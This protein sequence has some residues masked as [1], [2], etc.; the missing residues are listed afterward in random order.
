MHHPLTCHGRPARRGSP[1]LGLAAL[2]AAATACSDPPPPTFEVTLDCA[3][4]TELLFPDTAPGETAA[5]IVLAT[6][7]DEGESGAARPALEGT[8]AAMF[9]IVADGTTCSGH[10][11]VPGETC[12]TLVEYKPTA[13][14]AHAATLR[15]GKTELALG[16]AAVAA[17]PGLTASIRSAA[18]LHGFFTVASS[19]T[20]RL[21]NESSA[22]ITLSPSTFTGTGAVFTAT[23]TC[24]ATLTPGTA[25]ELTLTA[26]PQTT[27]CAAGTFHLPTSAR[28]IE[29][30]LSVGF[31]GGVSLSLSGQGSGRVVSSPP[32]LDCHRDA[33]SGEQT[34]RCEQAFRAPVTLTAIPDA[35][36][37]F[38][39]WSHSACAGGEEC[40]LAPAT[41]SPFG[42]SAATAS[43]AFASPGAKRLEVTFA[44]SGK[45]FVRGAF[46]CTASCSGWLEPET[47]PQLTAGS[48]SRFIG[49]SGACS[50]S[51]QAC[52]LGIV[53]NDLATTV[54][55][56]A[57]DREQA[58]ILPR[59]SGSI[60]LGGLL[61]DGDLV[62]A[63]EG[64]GQSSGP[65]IARLS[66]AGDVRWSAT[67]AAGYA[68]GLK[69]TP[70]GEIYALATNAGGSSGTLSKLDGTG[71]IAWQR[72]T[73]PPIGSVGNTSLAVGPGGAAILVNGPGGGVVRSYAAD[74]SLAWAAPAPPA[75]AIAIDPAGITAVAS[76]TGIVQRFSAAGAALA[77]DWM[78]PPTA[79]GSRV[80][81]AYD[82]QGFLDAQ[83]LFDPSGGSGTPKHT[84]S[85]LDL[86]GALIFEAPIPAPPTSASSAS[87]RTGGIAV[88]ASAT[89][90]S[91]VSHVYTGRFGFGY[92]AGAL[93]E[94]YDPQGARTWMLDKPAVPNGD[95]R[96]LREG[97]IVEDVACGA[98]RCAL[99]GS[100]TLR[101]IMVPWIQVFSV[102]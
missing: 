78:L 32:G 28:T 33:V 2:A 45:G 21:I 101:D 95:V 70:S 46:N 19:H 6:R 69:V 38:N 92:A 80:T 5:A 49:W 39:G 41:M 75:V 22:D 48:P 12:V 53:V 73:P 35:G 63:T 16:G 47:R 96:Q 55:F 84:L 23:P 10:A 102:P 59:L 62:V 65:T 34:G 7:T 67:L 57:D 99:F 37:H 11:L 17:P 30:P 86:T 31:L 24:P 20:L 66:L 51:S 42:P 88:T 9:R 82:A 27:S 40:I 54:T 74:G 77:P 90:F 87:A 98:G 50:G 61:P 52:D 36:H 64:G 91:W 94:A 81:L 58:T 43:A 72:E 14:G 8:D 89:V 83:T 3:A 1:I 79:S 25:C 71:A 97:I 15:L 29:I 60:V 85:R 56:D 18:S 93:L 44:G 100:Y 13:E 4:A 76:S 68:A 26:T